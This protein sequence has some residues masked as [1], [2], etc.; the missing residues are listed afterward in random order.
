MF[1][2]MLFLGTLC[3]ISI[4]TFSVWFEYS[5]CEFNYEFLFHVW[6]HN[7]LC[8]TDFQTCMECHVFSFWSGIIYILGPCNFLF[9]ICHYI[10]SLTFFLIHFPFYWCHGCILLDHLY[11]FLRTNICIIKFSFYELFLYAS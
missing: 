6:T 7:L 4:V 11:S 9:D 10:F 5:S 3:F 2:L 8:R 1:L